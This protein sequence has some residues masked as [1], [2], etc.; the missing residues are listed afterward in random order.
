[1][2]TRKGTYPVPNTNTYLP[3]KR[4]RF[5]FTGCG[6]TYYG[7]RIR[8]RTVT[9]R[10]TSVRNT[11]N[12]RSINT[13]PCDTNAAV[14]NP[15]I[16]YKYFYLRLHINTNNFTF[17]KKRP[18]CNIEMLHHNEIQLNTSIP[19]QEALCMQLLQPG[20]DCGRVQHRIHPRCVFHS[21]FPTIYV[22]LPNSAPPAKS[23]PSSPSAIPTSP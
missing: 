14:S 23:T 7:I 18:M 6:M 4:F 1:M 22:V 20:R 13:Y 3:F 5:G 17:Q 11:I 2:D 21:R 9:N 19:D 12:L 15:F 10:G 8:G 16:F